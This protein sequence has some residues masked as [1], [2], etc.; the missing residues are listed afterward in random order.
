YLNAINTAD[1]YLGEIMTALK[2]REDYD[3]EEW[4]VI[5]TSN[6]GGAGDSFGGSSLN[7]RNTFTLFYNKDFLPLKLDP[8]FIEAPDFYQSGSNV[9]IAPVIEATDASQYN[10]DGTEMSVE[11][12]LKRNIKHPWVGQPIIMGKT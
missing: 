4:L 10:F 8:S 5:V 9:H 2:E 7:E 1:G 3:S 12:R 11:F 6:H